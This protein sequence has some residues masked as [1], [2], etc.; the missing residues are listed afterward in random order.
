[1]LVTGT[2]NRPD[3]KKKHLLCTA[4]YTSYRW[5]PAVQTRPSDRL[6]DL[7]LPTHHLAVA[8]LYR[9]VLGVEGSVKKLKIELALRGSIDKLG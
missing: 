9:S 8:C 1:M 5:Q 3:N 4:I 2:W 7:V 6:P